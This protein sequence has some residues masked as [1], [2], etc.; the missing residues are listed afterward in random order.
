[1]ERKKGSKMKSHLG[2]STK[3]VK[4]LSGKVSTLREGSVLSERKRQ[5]NENVKGVSRH[6]GP[7]LKKSGRWRGI[8]KMGRSQIRKNSAG[9]FGV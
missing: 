7:Q 1:L 2:K 4:R 8:R 6:F 3:G 5:R 9:A